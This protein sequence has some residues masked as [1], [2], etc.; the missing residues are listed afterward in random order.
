[1]VLTMAM[2]AAGTVFATIF[3]IEPTWLIPVVCA[4]MVVGISLPS[5]FI[6]AL[7]LRKRNLGPLL[8]ANGWAINTKAKINIPFGQSLT[9]VAVLPVGSLRNLVDP[10][11]EEHNGRKWTIIGAVAMILGVVVYFW[12]CG[13]F[14]VIHLKPHWPGV[15]DPA[16]NAVPA[17]STTNAATNAVPATK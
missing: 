16:T 15:K 5:V 4:S 8:D 12:A 13:M 1:M 10:F 7:K 9:Q 6:A 2:G 11:A 17:L 3:K 14:T